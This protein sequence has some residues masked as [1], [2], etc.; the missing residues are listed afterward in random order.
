MYKAARHDGVRL[1]IANRRP[2]RL[3]LRLQQI[4]RST[5]HQFESLLGGPRDS[6]LRGAAFFL[7]LV[8]AAGGAGGISARNCKEPAGISSSFTLTSSRCP[9]DKEGVTRSTTTVQHS[10]SVR[11]SERPVCGSRSSL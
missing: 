9:Y 10:C 8:S 3:A 6:S 1:C 7:G 2:D 11:P 5:D 4:N